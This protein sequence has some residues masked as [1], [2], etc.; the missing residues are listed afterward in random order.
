[1]RKLYP[2]IPLLLMTAGL[3]LVGSPILGTISAVLTVLIAVVEFKLQRPDHPASS[4]TLTTANITLSAVFIVL[5]LLLLGD[6]IIR[7]EPFTYI[8]GRA[9][10]M[11]CFVVTLITATGEYRREKAYRLAKTR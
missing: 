1:M 3:Y 8:L 7:G 4:S 2:T 11:L 9:L 6:G 5:N 10:M